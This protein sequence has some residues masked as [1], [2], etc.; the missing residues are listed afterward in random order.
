ML[1][2]SKSTQQEIIDAVIAHARDFEFMSGIDRSAQRIRQSAEV[3]TP[4][5][6]VQ[7]MLSR[8]PVE[9]FSDETKTV[10]D[11][12]CGDGQF[13]SEV[14]IRKLENGIAFEDALR[15]IYGIDIKFDNVELCRN[16]LLCGQESLRYI[17]NHNIVC[18]DALT[19]NYDKF[20]LPL[21]K[22]V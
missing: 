1:D 3:F 2:F 19:Y 5:A 9:L 4:T 11:P 14:L 15:N 16:R 7:E 12:S 17:V 18:G 20:D 8:L 10:I 6:L 13:L 21:I 22:P